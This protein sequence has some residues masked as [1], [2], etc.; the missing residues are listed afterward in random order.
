[1]ACL[2]RMMVFISRTVSFLPWGQ[3]RFL[4][5]ACQTGRLPRVPASRANRHT[6]KPP[7][8]P[9]LDLLNVHAGNSF[10][11]ERAGQE[12][13][14]LRIDP[15]GNGA[16]YA[17]PDPY[18]S[19]VNS[20]MSNQKPVWPMESISACR[21]FIWSSSSFARERNISFAS[22]DFSLAARSR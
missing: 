8:A 4:P 15:A 7:P 11:V 20:C 22:V 12:Y 18:C 16:E 21:I 13:P 19:I 14:G 2:T 10:A 3:C 5:G 1:M 6:G 17:I 9:F